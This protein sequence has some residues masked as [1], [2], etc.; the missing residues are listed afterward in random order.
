[1]VT[2]NH[3]AQGSTSWFTPVDQNW[4]TLENSLSAGVLV[5]QGT[6]TVTGGEQTTSS[7]TFVDVTG[8][9]VT[10][11]LSSTA[12]VAIDAVLTTRLVV[13]DPYTRTGWGINVDG[14]DY[15][16]GTTANDTNYSDYRMV[17]LHHELSL[18]AGSHTVKVRF[19]RIT[20]GPCR[21]VSSTDSPTRLYVRS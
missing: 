8:A 3:P 18:G 7:A 15:N 9:S 1:M 19:E 2:L 5:S 12:W 10:F 21:V 20:G 16:I 14:T 13:G 6:A 4:T 17:S 11:S